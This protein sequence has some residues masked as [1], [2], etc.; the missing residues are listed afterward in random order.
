LTLTSNSAGREAL[1]EFHACTSAQDITHGVVIWANSVGGIHLFEYD[2]VTDNG[3]VY[4]L[5]TFSPHLETEGA[6]IN[7]PVFSFQVQ[8][9]TATC[10][11]IHKAGEYV[12]GNQ[13]IALNGMRPARESDPDFGDQGCAGDPCS[14]CVLMY[15]TPT[16]GNA[17]H[18]SCACRTAATMPGTRCNHLINPAVPP[19]T[20]AW[21]DDN[22]DG[23]GDGG[24][25]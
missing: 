8:P 14:A 1:I 23:I 15:N 17:P 19:K 10:D 4:E 24:I 3:S 20:N 5:E 13:P 18:Y 22:G 2:I 7:V 9:A 21:H 12:L 16:D 25:W 11:S 6:P